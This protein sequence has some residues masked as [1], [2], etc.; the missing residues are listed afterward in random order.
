[1]IWICCAESLKRRFRE[2]APR[3]NAAAKVVGEIARKEMQ[4]QSVDAYILDEA[5]RYGIVSDS[6]HARLRYIYEERC[7]FGHPYEQRPGEEALLAAA[8]E[9]VDIVLSRDTKLRH[10]FIS[11]Q[12]RLL[13]QDATYL[14]DLQATVEKYAADTV[15]RVEETLHQYFLEQLWKALE[16]IAGDRSVDAFFR[17]GIWFAASYLKASG[18]LTAST[19]EPVDDL[20][21]WPQ[22]LS[23]VLATPEIFR[24]IGSHAS[25]MVVGVLVQAA[26]TSPIQLSRLNTLAEKALLSER[27]GERFRGAIAAM[28]PEAVAQSSVSPIHFIDRIIAELKTHTWPRQNPAIELIENMGAPGIN[29]LNAEQQF[30]LGNNVLQAADGGSRAAGM[31]LHRLTVADPVWPAAFIEGIVAEC[32]VNDDDEI[33]FKTRVFEHAIRSWRAVPDAERS[34]TGERLVARISNRSVQ[35]GLGDPTARDRAVC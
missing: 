14:D 28:P 6:E 24:A 15:P 17:R 30:R 1:M 35:Y 16:P 31:F 25:D 22:T 33:R 18:L 34:E 2:L 27:Q 29:R 12:V 11:Q 19:W 26:L 32:F 23:R 13:I 9:V 3:D 20:T 10:G 8:A 4:Q 5:K 7:V 21:R